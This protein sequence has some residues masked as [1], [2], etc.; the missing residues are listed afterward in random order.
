MPMRP[1]S[2]RVTAAGPS[3]W[4]PLNTYATSIAILLGVVFS[5]NKNLTVDVEY[6]S[7]Q[8]VPQD[9]KI[10]RSTTTAT[11]TLTNHGLSV[12]DSIVVSQAGAPLD[13]TYAVA[14]VTNQN[15]ITYTVAN[16]GVTTT[17]GKNAQVIPL[18]ISDHPVLSALTAN[19]DSNF[20][21][22]PS[23]VRLT[24]TA[25]TAG[26]ADLNIRSGSK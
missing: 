12:G 1:T 7:D 25:F 16:S 11:L 4:V 8:L 19:A 9:C 3:A 23:V 22:P 21:V 2:V 14:S 24:C 15:V 17:Q 10:T 13:G 20:T 26:Y 18:R 5:S 6:S